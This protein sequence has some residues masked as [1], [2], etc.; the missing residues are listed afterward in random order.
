ME[1]NRTKTYH[2]ECLG[3]LGLKL[4]KMVPKLTVGVSGQP[5]PEMVKNGLKTYHLQRL[6]GLGSK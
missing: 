5:V 3:G 6:G 1:Q 4:F 2:L